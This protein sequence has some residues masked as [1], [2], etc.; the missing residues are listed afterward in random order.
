[1]LSCASLAL[2]L[3]NKRI[4][5]LPFSSSIRGAAVQDL[6]VLE[7]MLLDRNVLADPADCALLYLSPLFGIEKLIIKRLDLLITIDK[8]VLQLLNL[9]PPLIPGL[10]RVVQQL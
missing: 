2:Y 6:L 9:T 8:L 5:S 3:S 10:T 1:M 4:V 7:A